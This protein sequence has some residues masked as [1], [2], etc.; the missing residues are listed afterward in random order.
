M[1]RDLSNLSRARSRQLEEE[2]PWIWLYDIETPDQTRYRLTNYDEPVEFGSATTGAALVYSPAPIVHGDLAESG[3]GDLPRFQLQLSNESLLVRSPME[4]FDGFVGQPIT[5]RLVNV[6]ELANPT[7]TFRFDGEIA[8][9]KGSLDRVSIDVSALSL[10]QSVFP[11]ERYLRNHCRYRYGDARCG[12]DL[13][14]SVLLAAHPTCSKIREGDTGCDAHG[15]AEIAAGL[16][17][18]H[19]RRFGGWPGIPRISRK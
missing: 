17:S 6:Q 7:A 14:N 13:T 16:A 10:A 12:Y 2:L 18:K 9:A 4:S 15:L 3:T 5:I 1:P 19:P 11:G 8:G